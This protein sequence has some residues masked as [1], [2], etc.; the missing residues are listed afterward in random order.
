VTKAAG[1]TEDQQFF[2]G[3]GQ[4]WCQKASDEIVRLRA[5]TDTHSAARFRVNG[6]LSHLPEFAAAFSCGE[7]TPMRRANACNVW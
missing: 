3:V 6:P 5:R 4:A 2:L 1:F 7:G